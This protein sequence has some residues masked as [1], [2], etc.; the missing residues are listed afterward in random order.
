MYMVLLL[1]L[2]ELVKRAGLFF[3]I[4]LHF[5]CV[6]LQYYYLL[7]SNSPLYLYCLPSFILFICVPQTWIILFLSTLG[8]LS[9]FVLLIFFKK[10]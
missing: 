7:S 9:C 10:N 6:L 1:L 2:V 3:C 5:S 4:Q 8:L